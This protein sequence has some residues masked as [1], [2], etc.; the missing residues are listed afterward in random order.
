MIAKAII[1][2]AAGVAALFAL[3]G[4]KA[5]A[6]TPRPL[7]GSVPSPAG[8]GSVAERMAKVLATNDPNAIRFEAARLKQEG[9]PA[10]AAELEREAARLEKEIA[11][12]KAPAPV[13]PA[14][15]PVKPPTSIPVPSVVPGI[16]PNL[17]PTTMPSIPVPIPAPQVPVVVPAGAYP[18][19]PPMPVLPPAST[20]ILSF[21][22]TYAKDGKTPTY[23]SPQSLGDQVKRLQHRLIWLGFSLG[24]KGADGKY[25][26]DTETAVKLFQ[27]AANVAAVQKVAGTRAAPATIT[28][29]GKAGAQTLQRLAVASPATG[30]PR[31]G[32]DVFNGPG[33]P[34][35][36]SPLPGLI[37]PMAPGFVDPRRALTARVVTMLLTTAP[38]EEDKNLIAAFQSQEGLKASGW[39]NPSTAAAIGCRYGIIPPKPLYWPK[40]ATGKAKK[41][42][43]AQLAACA[44]QDPQR[45]EEWARAALV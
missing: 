15:A 36:A 5:S 21:K 8:A 19:A 17:I 38:G 12:G 39:Y 18:V 41:N 2:I 23:V 25:G 3:G 27:T 40:T 1:P 24:P 6:A 28:V 44:E 10:Q 14:P 37:R 30:G 43:Q 4:K 31:F 45:A 13:Y 9:Y 11:A 35:P 42:Y 34:V 16:P 32:A 26:A 29:D 33:Y 20:G 7:P 22:R